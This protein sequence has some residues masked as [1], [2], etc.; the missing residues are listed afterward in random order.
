LRLADCE[1]ARYVS[2]VGFYEDSQNLELPPP[3]PDTF[4]VILP[5]LRSLKEALQSEDA[6]GVR[7]ASQAIV[8]ALAHEYE[9]STIPWVVVEDVRPSW[10]DRRGRI[11]GQT[12][13]E[14]DGNRWELKLFLRT[15]AKRKVVAYKTFLNTLL[16]E[17]AHFYDF[18]MLGGTIHTA[19]FYRRL[20]TLYRLFRDVKVD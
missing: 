13:G 17:F 11:A 16:H 9:I 6:L 10:R 20:N 2:R 3:S 7:I 19:G 14:A 5:R 15:P 12:H 4:R 1:R 18:S 8:D